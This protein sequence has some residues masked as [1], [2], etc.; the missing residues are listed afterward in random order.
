MNFRFTLPARA[1]FSPGRSSLKKIC[2]V[3]LMVLCWLPC[4]A[5]HMAVVVNKGNSTGNVTA[6]DLTKIFEVNTRKWPDGK[7]ITV[8]IR[9]LSSL[10]TQEALQ[11]L[12]KMT[13][14]ELKAFLDGHKGAFVTVDSDEALL[15]IVETTPG[16]VGLVDVYSITNRVNVVKVDGKLPLEQGYLLH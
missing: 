16:A 7:N 8:V 9:D 3:L 4:E 11:R 5:K 12:Y 1:C 10:E 6:V 15:K 2:L 13:Q 14:L